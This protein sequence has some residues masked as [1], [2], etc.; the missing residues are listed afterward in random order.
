M[1][2]NVFVGTDASME[3]AQIRTGRHNEAS[4]IVLENNRAANP[5]VLV[6]DQPWHFHPA[7]HPHVEVSGEGWWL[8]DWHPHARRAT[9]KAES[10]ATFRFQGTR[11]SH[12]AG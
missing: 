1:V 3:A 2:G 7:T 5:E 8:D 10:A 9:A 6:P 11:V 12:V 4:S